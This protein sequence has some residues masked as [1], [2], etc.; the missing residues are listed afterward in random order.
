MLQEFNQYHKD[1]VLEL[2]SAEASSEL[3]WWRTWTSSWWANV[4]F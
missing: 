4:Y 1:K 2:S 3:N